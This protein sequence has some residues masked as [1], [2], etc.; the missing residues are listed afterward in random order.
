M[1]GKLMK[2]WISNLKCA[3]SLQICCESHISHVFK[4]DAQRHKN[5]INVNKYYN[6]LV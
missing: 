1:W 6:N 3:V 5:R 4:Y 2:I